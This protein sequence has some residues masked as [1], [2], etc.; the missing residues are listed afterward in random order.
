MR[1]ERIDPDHA[2]HARAEDHNDG[3]HEAAAD[4]AAGGDGAVHE[5]A[6][7]VGE[8]HDLH[9]LHARGH[10]V[11]VVREDIE[12]RLAAQQKAHAEDRCDEERIAEADVIALHH[13]VL[14]PRAPVLAHEGRA[15]GIERGHHVVDHVVDVDRGGVAG[16]DG[17]IK[18]VDADLDEEIRHREDH[19]LDA[20]RDA[21]PENAAGFAPVQAQAL[22]FHAAAVLQ[23]HHVDEDQHSRQI[24]R[25]HACQRDAVGRHL[26]DDDE[27][28][29]ED[30]VQNA[31]RRQIGQRPL[32]IA[33]RA[34]Y[35]VAEVENAERRHA[36]RVDAEIEHRAGQQIVLRPEQLQH[37]RGQK[38]AQHRDHE[39]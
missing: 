19:M 5:R 35:R 6:D 2:E 37:R 27:E 9:P 31:R 4:A 1:K 34:Q 10:D 21:E 3:R 32:R 26:A 13:P 24:L 12:E 16:D 11:R 7:T 36:E 14:V 8:A 30:H 20:S 29:I 25:K 38:K 28:Q 23:P 22:S 17:G 18:R 39:P 33:A 15:G